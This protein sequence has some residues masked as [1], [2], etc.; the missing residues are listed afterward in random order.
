MLTEALLERILARI[1]INEH[2]CWL[3]QG[4]LSHG[5]GNIRSGDRHLRVHRVVYLELVGAPG[6]VLDHLCRERACCNPDHLEPVSNAENVRRGNN[7]ASQLVCH[8]GHWMLGSN[9]VWRT[10]GARAPERCCRE[11]ERDRDRRRRSERKSLC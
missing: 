2:G 10:K 1:E 4:A 6:A 7:A 11:C 9:V 8:R 5:Y 3:W